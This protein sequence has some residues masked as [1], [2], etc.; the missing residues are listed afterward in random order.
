MVVGAVVAVAFVGV[1]DLIH[2]AEYGARR[3]YPSPWALLSAML[4]EARPSSS[5]PI[6]MIKLGAGP[7]RRRV[8]VGAAGG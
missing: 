1:V 8:V 4:I 3:S 7:S 2:G 6:I 5:I